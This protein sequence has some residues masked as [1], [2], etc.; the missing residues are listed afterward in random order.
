MPPPFLIVISLLLLISFLKFIHKI[1]WIPL[2]IQ[3]HFKKQGIAGPG[4]RPLSGNLGELRRLHAAAQS[5]KSM[6]F[7]HDIIHRVLPFYQEWSRK[8]G[9]MFLFWYGIKPRLVISDPDMIK[10][11]LMNNK[12][13]GSIEKLALNP[14]RKILFGEGLVVLEGEKWALHRRIA[15]QAFNLE[16][17][18]KVR[19]CV[20][21]P[22]SRIL[23]QSWVPD[24]VASTTNVLMKWEE[25]RGGR[26]EFE[27]DVHKEFHDLS[28]EIIS[29]TAFG[30]SYEQGKRIF[31]LQEE[32]MHLVSQALRSVYIPGFRF[33][34][35]KNN[36]ERWRL[37]ADT[38]E[39]IK[40]LIKINSTSRDNS[41]NL[42]SLLMSSCRNQDGKE[43]TLE[44]EEVI[45]ECKTFYVEGKETTANVLTW[46]L[47]LLAS[48]QEWQERASEEVFHVYGGKEV[49]G[50]D[51]LSN[52]KILGLII[53]ET[54]RLYPPAATLGRQTSKKVDLVN[55]AV[56]AG[57]QLSV[58][59]TAVHH[60]TDIWGEDANEFNPSRFNESRKRLASFFSVRS[61]PVKI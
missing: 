16:Q 46:A 17:V 57:T 45:D 30:S 20:R 48:H 36:R 33:L 44:A 22:D 60:D 10:E 55:L 32:Q 54:L 23:F 35:T 34:P 1:I 9:K 13:A 24:T 25:I 8:Y 39:A 29:R 14:L 42:P 38:R 2:R 50:A 26:E 5:S 27:L 53:N 18:K 12:I 15:N 4:Y 51:N 49:L 19:L 3:Y 40:H 11:V 47:L 58:P 41:R 31:T 6:P 52:L 21:T 7:S 59:L 43:E 61:A 56:P 37:D 28:A